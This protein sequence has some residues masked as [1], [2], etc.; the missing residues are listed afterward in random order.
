MLPP[1]MAENHVP[2]DQMREKISILSC[3]GWNSLRISQSVG[4]PVETLHKHYADECL[5]GRDRVVMQTALRYWAVFHTSSKGEFGR[6][7]WDFVN[8][9]ATPAAAKVEPLGKKDQAR[10]DAG[11]PNSA[12][13]LGSLIGERQQSDTVN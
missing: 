10:V 5:R 3:M 7:F 8:D 4:L 12:T 2:T 1:K 6:L 11:L 13:P 9:Q